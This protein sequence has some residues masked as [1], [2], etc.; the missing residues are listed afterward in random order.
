V[1]ETPGAADRDLLHRLESFY[2]A[3]PRSGARVEEHGPLRLFVREGAGW[4]YYAR[5][6]TPDVSVG[7]GDVQAVL[8]RMVELDVPRQLEWV[9]DL[10]P[11]LTAAVREVGLEL[12]L[13]PMMVLEPAELVVPELSG[14]DVRVVG[15]DDPDLAAGEA[16]AHLGFGAGIGTRVGEAG[17][18]EREAALAEVD[19]PR[20][21]RLREALSAGTQVRVLASADD[22]VLGSGGYQHAEGV[23]EVVGVATLPSARRRGIGNA[24]AAVLARD[25]FARGM[26]TVFLAAQDQDVAR[27][28]QRAG[29]HR[30]GTAG[31]ATAS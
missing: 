10:S 11:S 3:V 19:A 8:D 13:C 16:V 15:P 22:G 21:A 20:L 28:Y 31:I 4:P 17:P 14:V 25:A 26:H 2:D 18:A 5:P 12:E 9:H 7:P 24:V 6:V 1:T 30:V 29:F 23:A 27:V